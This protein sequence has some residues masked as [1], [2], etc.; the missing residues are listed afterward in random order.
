MITGNRQS[1]QTIFV[2]I[3]NQWIVKKE[4]EYFYS[5]FYLNI[6]IGWVSDCC[7]MPNEQF[8]RYFM[9]RTSYIRWDDHDVCFVIDQH[10]DLDFYSASSMKR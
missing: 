5:Q 4:K 7:L 3:L 8:F 1:Q 9:E 6:Y 2:L 10:A